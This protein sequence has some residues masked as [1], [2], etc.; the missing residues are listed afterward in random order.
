MKDDL[1]AVL[2]EFRDH[3][4]RT[5]IILKHRLACHNLRGNS[6]VQLVD[7]LIISQ[8]VQYLDKLYISSCRRLPVILY[9]LASELLNNLCEALK[10][11]IDDIR[12]IGK[13]CAE[14]VGRCVLFYISH[15]FRADLLNRLLEISSNRAD[16]GTT[17]KLVI[18]TYNDSCLF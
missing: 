2:C 3:F 14:L 7:T 12:F 17:C 18:L 9:H 1:T 15:L 8:E 13:Q 16:R 10:T 6:T 4:L 11:D 5:Y